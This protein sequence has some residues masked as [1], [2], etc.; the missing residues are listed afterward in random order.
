MPPQGPVAKKTSPLVWILAGLGVFVVFIVLC[1]VALG[2]FAV[3]KARQ[4][5]L[6]PDLMKRNPALATAKMMAAMNPDVQVVSV[7]EGRG[8]MTVRNKK[9]GKTVTVNFEDAKKG[10]FVFS[11]DGKNVEMSTT[12]SGANGGL[13]IKSSDGST[14]KIGGAAANVPTW[15]PQYPG[16]QA[17][18]AFT[19]NQATESGGTF[20]FK[21][22]DSADKV[23][24]WYQDQLPAA[25][26]K[27][28]SNFTGQSAGSSG[29]MM[30]AEDAASKRN[31]TVTVGTES[32][33]TSV[34]VM[35][36]EKK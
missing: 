4:A 3:H 30:S 27:I 24:K 32:G 7:D 20:S 35:Y 6:D 21:T 33:A 19:S 1:V 36:S 9:D 8:V 12:G 26:M 14:V 29:A 15:V 11:E 23:A 18:N 10:K 17:Q 5:G 25:G 22:N 34:A 16:A 13:E 28:T 2:I 31:V